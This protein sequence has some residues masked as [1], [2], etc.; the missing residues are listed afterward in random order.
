MCSF[1]YV[2]R[3]V[4]FAE[5]SLEAGNQRHVFE[6]KKKKNENRDPL[7]GNRGEEFNPS[8]PRKQ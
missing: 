1:A 2:T 3:S 5:L 8:F 6:I 4:T 7:E